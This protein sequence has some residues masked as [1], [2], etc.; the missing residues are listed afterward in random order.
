M[1]ELIRVVAV[2]DAPTHE[3]QTWQQ[4]TPEVKGEAE[5]LTGL[6]IGPW[7][8]LACDPHAG[9]ISDVAGQFQLL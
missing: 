3:I 4:P 7:M 8:V 9:V 1:L 6:A 2:P 5:A